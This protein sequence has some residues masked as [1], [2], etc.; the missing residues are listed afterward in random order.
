MKIADLVSYV[1]L[2]FSAS[3]LLVFTVVVSL[4]YRIYSFGGL[5]IVPPQT[6]ILANVLAVLG[7]GTSVYA[8]VQKG[9]KISSLTALG[10][11]LLV[12]SAPYLL[13]LF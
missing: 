3:A 10:V 4:F 12:L 6:I 1:A 8:L 11:G 7:I 2:F 5:F 9:E 13:A